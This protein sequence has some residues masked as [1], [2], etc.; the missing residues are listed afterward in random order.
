MSKKGEEQRIQFEALQQDQK[1]NRLA[2]EVCFIVVIAI[3]A[4]AAFIEAFSY[5]LVSSRT[6]FV[7]LVPLLLLIGFQIIRLWRAP[8]A[9]AVKGRIIA[10][11]TGK[12]A[13][14]NKTVIIL[15]WL[16]VAFGTIILFGHYAG[17][18]LLMLVL[19][20]GIARENWRLTSI[21]VGSMILIIFLVFEPGFDIELYR[22]MIFRHFAGYRVF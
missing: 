22:G 15:A 4:I 21:V 7:F 18:G 6:P 13:A 2:L 9:A 14:F 12:N 16:L 8:D 10:A 20:R 1:V 11:F 17:L 5:E 19:M 3:I